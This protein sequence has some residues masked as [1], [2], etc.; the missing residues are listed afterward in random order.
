MFVIFFFADIPTKTLDN[1]Q[2]KVLYI[3]Q[4]I[5][6]MVNIMGKPDFLEILNI[7]KNI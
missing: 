2:N 7:P 4:R 6:L 5:G 3:F 1:I